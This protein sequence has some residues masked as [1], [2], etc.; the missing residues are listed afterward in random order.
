MPNN[1]ATDAY[2]WSHDILPGE[3][4]LWSGQ[5]P[6]AVRIYLSDLYLLPIGAILF[7]VATL[8][9]LG[10]FEAKL[11]GVAMLMLLPLAA[12]LFLIFGIRWLDWQDRRTTHYA[13]T[14]ERIYFRR[15]ICWP[16]RRYYYLGNL[17]DP[18]LCRT[19]RGTWRITF[20][21]VPWLY[22][23]W[24]ADLFSWQNDIYPILELPREAEQLWEL[25]RATKQVLE[26]AAKACVNP[27]AASIVN[28]PNFPNG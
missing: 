8:F 6:Q 15:G 3:R 16:K 25:I 17:Q 20:G 27:R 9:T 5:P 24:E 22:M 10:L 14:N 23:L 4:L 7:G 2:D 21:R 28:S 13:L 11:P 1:G 19:W 26:P 18:L 12:G